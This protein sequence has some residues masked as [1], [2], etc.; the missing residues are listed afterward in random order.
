MSPSIHDVVDV[1]L[2]VLPRHRHARGRELGHAH[3]DA[4]A[5]AFEH[6]DDMRAGRAVEF[7]MRPLRGAVAHQPGRD[8]ARAVAALLRLRAVG[9]EDAIAR[10]PH[11]GCAALRR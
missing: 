4:I 6:V 3:R 5:P 1:A 9:V 11:A 8:A 2:D 7:E 10:R